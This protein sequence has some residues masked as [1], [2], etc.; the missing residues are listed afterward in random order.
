MSSSGDEGT[1][2]RIREEFPALLSACTILLIIICGYEIME[3]LTPDSL[4]GERGKA[5][6]IKY[7][8]SVVEILR[9]LKQ[10]YSYKE[11]SRI[12]GVNETTLCRYIRGSS[13]PSFEQAQQIWSKLNQSLDLS[14][15]ILRGINI[16]SEGL[17]EYSSLLTDP[18]ILKVLSSRLYLE[19]SGY[20]ITKIV[21]KENIILSL[22]TV[23]SMYLN[24][25][26]FIVSDRVPLTKDYIVE[27][28]IEPPNKIRTIYIPRI[29]ARKREEVIILWD[30]LKDLEEVLAVVRGLEKNKMYIHLVF[31]LIVI[32][33]KPLRDSRLQVKYL[34]KI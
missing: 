14:S 33:D 5:R 1:R 31:A 12:T 13:I 34:F 7:R 26:L 22:A 25:G 9:Y 32:G 18:V 24:A 16:S 17:L 10:F 15:L 21:T 8:I 19:L 30:L 27:N 4:G 11:L 28:I 2:N 6:I 23:L 20:R 3:A 29:Q